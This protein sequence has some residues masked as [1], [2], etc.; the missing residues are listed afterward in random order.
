M[1]FVGLDLGQRHDHTAL[2]VVE[3]R[4]RAVAWQT[5]HEYEGLVLR[6][7]ERV[8]LGTPYPEV[9]ERVRELV[10]HDEL[11]GRC[12]L[13][14]DATGVGA[15][16][17]EMLRAA[18]L[19]CEVTAVTITGGERETQHAGGYGVP[20]RD[21]MAGVQVLLQSGGLRMSR[22]VREIG[23]LVKELVDVQVRIGESGRV[24]VGA[25]AY[26]QHDDL[27][28]A[29]ALACWKAGRVAKKIGFQNRRIPG[30]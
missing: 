29:L 20:K 18:R 21:L 13:A 25:D 17:V 1:Y 12:A 6:H 26:G 22:E 2:A 15:P 16:V 27:V 28:I 11:A 5:S 30:I 4:Q 7:V 9:V 8:P 24:R 14:V 3:R 10:T 19:G 23:A